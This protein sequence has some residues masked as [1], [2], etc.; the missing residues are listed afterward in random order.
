MSDYGPMQGLRFSALG[1]LSLAALHQSAPPQAPRTARQAPSE[2]VFTA[3]ADFGLGP[4]ASATLGA[5]GRSGARLHLALGDLSYG[6]LGSERTWC[7]FV[8]AR[9]GQTPFQ[10]LAG[11]HEADWDRDGHIDKFA[12]CL[13]D[14]MASVGEY[15]REYY[16]D[17]PG[18]AR[19][20]LLSPDLTIDGKHY[21][22]GGSN[23]HYAWAVRAIRDARSA[24]I[25][26]VIVAMHKSCL[27]MA[28]YYCHIYQE[29]FSLLIEEKV[30]LVLQGHDHSYQRTKQIASGAACPVVKVDAFNPACLAVTARENQYKKGAGPVFVLTAAGGGQLYEINERDLE[31]GYFA[32]WMG[33]NR[34]PR[35]GFSRFRLTRDELSGEFVGST[36]TSDFS[37]HFTIRR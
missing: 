35:H 6:G 5:M 7:D 37:D 15:A 10:I 25:P 12:A 31:A 32:A 9:V 20:I 22:Y 18:L 17:V 26:W 13:P 23:E 30:D 28:Q 19:F 1:L 3:A 21:F 34:K 14:R 29:L 33:A 36:A 27:S 16:F 4:E 8:K 11:N 24:K 2:F